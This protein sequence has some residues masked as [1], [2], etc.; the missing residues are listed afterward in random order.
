MLILPLRAHSIMTICSSSGKRQ[1]PCK[2]VTLPA[3]AS[4][5]VADD[6]GTKLS[7]NRTVMTAL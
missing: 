7:L 1:R 6:L 2:P 5:S 4:H 3:V